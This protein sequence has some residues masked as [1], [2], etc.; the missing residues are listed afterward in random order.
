RGAARARRRARREDGVSERNVFDATASQA[1]RD[2]RQELGH[3]LVLSFA[4]ILRNSRS[5]AED[6]D[7][8]TPVLEFLQQSIT[9]MLED[10]AGVIDA[11][12]EQHIRSVA[13]RLDHAGIAQLTVATIPESALGD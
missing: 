9:S 13:S 3:Q 7:V 5:Y 6:N 12:S 4:S 10:K 2:K 1:T 8:F 11:T